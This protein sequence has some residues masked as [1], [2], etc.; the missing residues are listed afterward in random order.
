MTRL[1]VSSAQN[2]TACPPMPT[3]TATQ[4]TMH[5]TCGLAMQ[6]NWPPEWQRSRQ[7]EAE[8][9]QP[10]KALSRHSTVSGDAP[11]SSKTI[12]VSQDKFCLTRQILSH[13]TNSVS[14]DNFCLTRQILSHKTISV[15]QDKFCLTRQILSHKTNSVSQDI[16]VVDVNWMPLR[17]IAKLTYGFPRY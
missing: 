8:R 16:S 7:A 13:K 11:L 14:Q 10:D 6:R 17:R 15:S 1:P 12:S 3:R 9:Q 4:E 5:S 2:A